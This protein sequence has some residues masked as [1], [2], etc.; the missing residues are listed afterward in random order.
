MK[1]TTAFS[2]LILL[3]PT[4]VVFAQEHSDAELG[5]D[6]LTSPTKIVLEQDNQTTEGIQFYE[7]EFELLDDMVSLTDFGSDEPGF[8]THADD[9]LLFNAGDGISITAL[10]ASLHSSFGVGYVNYFAPGS[11]GL[12]AAGRLGISDESGGTSDLILD[13]T[14]SSGDPLQLIQI[15]DPT[16]NIHEHVVIDLLDDQTL[17]GVDTSLYGAY[18]VLFQ[19]HSD[20]GTLDAAD[21]ITSDPFWIVFNHGMDEEVFDS[22]ALSQF[23]VSAVPEPG[24]LAVLLLAGGMGVLRR[25]RRS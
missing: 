14:S 1:L 8:E 16:G 11:S 19:L 5:Y 22:V 25:R 20:F 23:G 3:M 15:A 9:D 2:A 7:S 21:D 13:G 24:S 4:T 18:G 10:D 12:T 6:N 17:A